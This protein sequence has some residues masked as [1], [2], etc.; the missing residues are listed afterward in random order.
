[1]ATKTRSKSTSGESKAHKSAFDWSNGHTG[2]L[3]GA[4]VAGAAVGLAANAGRK[5]FMQFGSGA[6]GDWLEAL[7]AEHDM[8]LALFDKIEAT[9]DSQTVMRSHLLTKLKYALSKHA[10]EEEMVIYPA[11]R[12]ADHGGQAEHLTSDHGKV[13]TFLYELET[14]ANDHPGW[15]A[16]VR[17]FRSAVDEHIREEEDTI[18]PP[19]HAGM[20]AEQNQKLTSMMNKEGFKAA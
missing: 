11:L 20:S 16:R 13:K 19:F 9:A 15:I 14:M 10:I 6:A 1:M 7:K 5:L 18:F 3:V 12:Q 4:A 8:V 2:V 17:E